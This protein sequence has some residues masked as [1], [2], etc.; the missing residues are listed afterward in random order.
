MLGTARAQYHLRQV[1]V[2]LN[3]YPVNQPEVMIAHA[4]ERFD[5]AGNLLDAQAKDLI[6]QL[7]S[8]LVAWTRLLQ[9]GQRE[10]A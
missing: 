7:L 6:R 8:N 3:M 4:A 10:R 5:A 1:F 9:Q 2:F